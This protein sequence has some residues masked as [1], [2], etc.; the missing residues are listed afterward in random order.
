MPEI[1]RD[2]ENG[3]LVVSSAEA[4]AAVDACRTLD[5]RAV[6]ASVE[7]RFDV[8]R[9]VDDYLRVYLTVAKGVR[10]P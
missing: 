3:F 2:G 9:M 10:C 7:D 6:R 4:V 1:V 8:G 5:R